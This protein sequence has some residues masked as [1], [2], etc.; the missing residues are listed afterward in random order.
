MQL[1]RSVE[2]VTLHS[3]ADASADAYG[4]ATYARYLYKDGTV[5]TS[6]VAFKTRVAP[7]SATSIPRLE[8]ME[9]VLGLR[10]A[11]PIAR[12]LKEPTD[13]LERQY[14]RLAVDSR[15][16][17]EL[18]AICGKSDWGDTRFE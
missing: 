10:L 2:A 1:D 16:Q 7:L 6:L 3:F 14:E 5:S 13:I 17:S 12:V 9:A 11:L 18:Q 4:T 8:L 15:S